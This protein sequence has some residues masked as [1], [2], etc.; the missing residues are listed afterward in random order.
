MVTQIFL[1]MNLKSG[2]SSDSV[3]KRL[4]EFAL[5]IVTKSSHTPQTHGQALTLQL[6]YLHPRH[7]DIII[8]LEAT[9]NSPSPAAEIHQQIRQIEV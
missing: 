9:S 7:M 2:E 1:N 3:H 8:H 4:K 5:E 6:P